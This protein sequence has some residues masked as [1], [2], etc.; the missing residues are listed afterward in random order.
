VCKDINDCEG[1]PCS[2]FGDF[3]ALCVDKVAPLRGYVCACGTVGFIFDGTNCVD[4]NSCE[5]DPCNANGDV[6]ATCEDYAPGQ[7]KTHACNCSIGYQET[8]VGSSETCLV[9]TQKSS[10]DE[11]FFD[12]SINLILVGSGVALF[13]FI[14]ICLLFW[15]RRRAMQKSKKCDAVLSRAEMELGHMRASREFGDLVET[16]VCDLPTEGNLADTDALR[17]A[18]KELEDENERL[19]RDVKRQKQQNEKSELERTTKHQLDISPRASFDAAFSSETTHEYDG[20]PSPS[21]L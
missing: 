3:N 6:N 19:R 2:A 14:M 7:N 8:S 12:N 1:A 5:N 10:S 20:P 15:Y 13:A 18:N 21:D 11:S 17:K 16:N 9:Q 4:E